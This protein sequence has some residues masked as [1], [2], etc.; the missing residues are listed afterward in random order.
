MQQINLKYKADDIV[1]SVLSSKTFGAVSVEKTSSSVKLR[2]EKEK[3]AQI[4]SLVQRQPKKIDKLLLHPPLNINLA[5]I[6]SVEIHGCS[7]SPNGNMIFVDY[8]NKK[9]ILL[10]ENRKLVKNIDCTNSTFGV[11]CISNESVAV[12]KTYSVEVINTE[13]EQVDKCFKLSY[14]PDGVVHFKTELMWSVKEKGIQRVD[15]QKGEI[16]TVVKDERMPTMTYLTTDGKNFYHP[17]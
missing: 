4:M 9:L 15:L 10:K 11:A 8:R 7:I 2:S 12:T 13:I 14:Y 16:I 5:E 17:K 3:Q 6:R 1:S